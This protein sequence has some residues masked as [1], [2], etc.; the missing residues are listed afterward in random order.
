MKLK[1][2]MEV[3]TWTPS[4]ERSNTAEERVVLKE[5]K[6]KKKGKIPPLFSLFFHLPSSYDL[7]DN[8]ARAPPRKPDGTFLI[9]RSLDRLLSPPSSTTMNSSP[10]PLLPLS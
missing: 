5:K 3:L 10:S 9:G 2:K 7:P 1:P 8:E 4:P 6:K